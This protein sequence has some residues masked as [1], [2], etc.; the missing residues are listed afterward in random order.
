MSY[1]LKYIGIILIIIILYIYWSNTENFVTPSSQNISI[2]SIQN[3][4]SVYNTGTLSASNLN[5]TNKITIGNTTIDVS[6]NITNGKVK[7]DSNGNITN[8]A[9]N[10]DSSGNITTVNGDSLTINSPLTVSGNVNLGNGLITTTGT[11]TA[12]VGPFEFGT[13]TSPTLI[14]DGPKSTSSFGSPSFPY[15]KSND[16]NYAIINKNNTGR[17]GFNW[18]NGWFYNT[19]MSN[20]TVYHNSWMAPHKY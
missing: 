5:I 9:I 13:M 16:V 20:N 17:A 3:L 12:N 7:I 18:N 4:A 19:M 8:G 2:E 14:W 6:G 11:T 15:I 1:N 10:I